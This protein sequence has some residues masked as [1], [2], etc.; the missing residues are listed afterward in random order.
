MNVV[1]SLTPSIQVCFPWLDTIRPSC[2]SCVRC[3]HGGSC[4]HQ[5]RCTL[6]NCLSSHS[7]CILLDSISPSAVDSWMSIFLMTFL[8][9]NLLQLKESLKMN[10]IHLTF[11]FLLA[12]SLLIGDELK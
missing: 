10:E 1:H 3:T 9:E 8:L 6:I 5:W 7:L 12:F 2:D 11:F 4:G